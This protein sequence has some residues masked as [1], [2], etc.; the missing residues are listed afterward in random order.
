MVTI[1]TVR[2]RKFN[3]TRKQILS[4]PPGTLG[5]TPMVRPDLGVVLEATASAAE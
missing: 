1:H 4:C 2:L 3:L 5:R